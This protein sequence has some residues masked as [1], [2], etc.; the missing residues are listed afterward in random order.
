ME[1]IQVYYEKHIRDSFPLIKHRHAVLFL[2]RSIV[3]VVNGSVCSTD[4]N[5]IRT[6]IPIANIS[7]IVLEPGTTITHEAVKLLAYCGCILLWIGENGCR[8]YSTGRTYTN[9][10][11]N[12][13][14]QAMCFA[15]PKKKN[16]VIYRLYKNIFGFDPPKNRSVEQ[17]RGF[18]GGIVRKN[19]KI[20][21][22]KY[23]VEWHGRD[24]D[25]RNQ[26]NNNL[27]NNCLNVANTCLYGIIEAAITMAGYS[28]DLGFI[29]SGHTCSFVHDVADIFKFSCATVPAFQAASQNNE[30]KFSQITR[31]ICIEKFKEKRLLQKCIPIINSL[32]E[33][34]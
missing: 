2:R 20:L 17:L 9:S 30:E 31:K 14:T 34:L 10:S 21:S 12:V 19:Y 18:E 22:K 23:D 15:N 25:I 5:G 3:D 1:E 6:C 13:E 28:P 29:H 7:V 27:I 8:I 32:F 4:K 11:R 33:D 24:Y 26:E 16:V